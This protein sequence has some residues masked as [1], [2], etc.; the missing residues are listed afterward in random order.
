MKSILSAA[1]L[2]L[3]VLAS[4]STIGE[5]LAAGKGGTTDQSNHAQWCSMQRASCPLICQSSNHTRAI[6]NECNS[7]TLAWDC[8]CSG[9]FRPDTEKYSQTVPYFLCMESLSKCT[10]TCKSDESC[11]TNCRNTNVCGATNPDLSNGT[12]TDTTPAKPTDKATPG[13]NASYDEGGAASLLGT[14][15]GYETIGYGLVVSAVTVMV[16]FNNL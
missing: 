14:G 7:A 12:T 3:A 9:N 16:S 11:V 6:K 10:N 1:I 8:I 15:S 4:M 2:S 5:V 13:F